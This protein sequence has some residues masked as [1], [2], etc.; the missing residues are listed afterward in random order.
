MPRWQPNQT[1]RPTIVAPG[2]VGTEFDAALDGE[3]LIVDWTGSAG[4]FNS[5]GAGDAAGYSAEAEDIGIPQ[6]ST[7]DDIAE[8]K[9][10]ARTFWR[11]MRDFRGG[12]GQR[13][14]DVDKVSLRSAFRD[15]YGIDTRTAGELKLVRKAVA[16]APGT[17]NTGGGLASEAAS[18]GVWFISQRNAAP[19]NQSVTH[20]DLTTFTSK[21]LAAGPAFRD[22]TISPDDYCYIA[23]DDSIYRVNLAGAVTKWTSGTGIQ[24][25][26]IRAAKQRLF[27]HGNDSTGPALYEIPTEGTA[28]AVAP[29]LKLR[30]PPGCNTADIK[31]AGALLLAAVTTPTQNG[32]GAIYAYDGVNAP[33]RAIVF[34]KG[35]DVLWITP[36]FGGSVVLIA[37]VRFI[38]STSTRMI[39][40]TAQ[41]SGTEI[42][43]LQLAFEYPDD[44]AFPGC[45]E[46]FVYGQHVF[47]AGSV[48]TGGAVR[49]LDAY[50]IVEGS[51]AHHLQS[52]TNDTDHYLGVTGFNGRL[53]WFH[54]QAGTVKVITESA[55]DYVTSGNLDSSAI[56]LNVDAPKTWLE[57]EVATRP[58][59]VGQKIEVYTTYDD[60]EVG[61]WRLAGVMSTPGQ[62]AASFPLGV[63]SIKVHLRV[64][65]YGTTTTTPKVTKLGVSAQMARLPRTTHSLKVNAYPRMQ[66]LDG[67]EHPEANAEYFAELADRFDALRTSGRPVWFQAPMSRFTGHADWVKVNKVVRKALNN[68]ADGFGGVLALELTNV[69]ADRINLWPLAVASL[70]SLPVNLAAGSVF[71]AI[72]AGGTT[73]FSTGTSGGWTAPSYLIVTPSQLSNGVRAPFPHTT[74][75]IDPVRYKGLPFSFGV[76]VRPSADNMSFTPTV[77][78][79]NAADS[80]VQ[81][82]AGA[83]VA[84]GA[85]TAG[86]WFLIAVENITF[87][88]LTATVYPTLKVLQTAGSA[89]AFG[90]D[91]W[92]MQQARLLTAWSPPPS[93]F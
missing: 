22:L 62:Q 89:A 68:P 45:Y 1:A 75:G 58:L 60:F 37:T 6:T 10:D 82:N 87:D 93:Q 56:D 44:Y 42:S 30:L 67:R 32:P 14:F 81:T 83:Q 3:P 12:F 26:V 85:G 11:S 13:R 49:P 63:T 9:L 27:A 59:A 17:F 16:S 28:G 74:K 24:F 29:I 33:Y 25:L 80:V 70:Y 5:L 61:D 43:N 76:L 78:G 51:I 2:R 92:Q 86:K 88:G 72:V 15:G 40:Y 65:L 47:F 73:V 38:T 79:F 48:I 77:E 84:F 18:D 39:L 4:L 91:A 41:V 71:E 90:V 8:N 57:V 35:E 54:D 34:N 20:Y 31:E 52:P 21:T 66:R 55:T 64:V 36:M 7:T 23:A 19:G 69:E 53:V 50:N 46:T